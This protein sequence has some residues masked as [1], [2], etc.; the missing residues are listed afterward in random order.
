MLIEKLWQTVRPFV[1]IQFYPILAPIYR[2]RRRVQLK[3]IEEGDRRY[4]AV[5]PSLKVPPA[6]LRY[7]VVGP[8]TI[9]QFLHG[10]EQTVNDIEAALQSINK[11]LNQF[12]ELL[13][14]GC[15]CGRL[16]L[17]LQGRRFAD[18]A[19]TAC[20]VDERAIR[21]CQQS[22]EKIKCVVNNALPPS[23]FENESFD[24]VWCGSV[25]THLDENRQDLWLAELRR[26]LKPNGILLASVHGPHLWEPRLPS[27]TIGKLRT[28]GLVFAKTG[29]DAGIHPSWYQVAW[30]T[31]KYIREHWASIFEIRAYRPRGFN[32]HQD[33]VV[34]QRRG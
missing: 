26:I 6:E 24:L 18:L 22:I 23:P 30:H 31:E 7:N 8:C 28:N 25:F 3:R 9:E 5:H 20:D 1:P 10:G 2:W 33:I 34:A 29:A 14:F 4:L 12:R 15:G 11:S 17:A 13:D 19:V 21:W 32:D 27:W 16:V